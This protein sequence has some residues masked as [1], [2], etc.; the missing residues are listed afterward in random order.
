MTTTRPPATAAQASLYHTL[1]THLTVLK[2]DACSE[3]LPRVL[4]EA[5]AEQ[6]TVTAT[7]ER[8]LAIVAR[9]HDGTSGAP[10]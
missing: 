10:V 6:L 3:A 9:Q 1:K 4:D 5:A 8:L 2:L 7:L